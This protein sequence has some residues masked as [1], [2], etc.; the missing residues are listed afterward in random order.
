MRVTGPNL[1]AACKIV[2]KI[3]KDDKNDHFF[4]DTNLLGKL[5]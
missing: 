2:F 5:K 3:A 4:R 1:A